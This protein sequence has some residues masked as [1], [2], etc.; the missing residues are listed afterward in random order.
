MKLVRSKSYVRLGWMGSIT[1]SIITRLLEGIGLRFR[2]SARIRI[3]IGCCIRTTLRRGFMSAAII[4]CFAVCFAIRS[5]RIL[6]RMI[7]L[8]T[9]LNETFSFCLDY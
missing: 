4:I 3:V 8:V 6:I 9:G 2:R 5:R 1:T 7:I